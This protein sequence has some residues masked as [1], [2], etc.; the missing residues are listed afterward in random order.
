MSE[1]GLRSNTPSE[2]MDADA[3]CERCDTVNPE[4]TLLCKTC[5]NNLRDQRARRLALEQAMEAVNAG[6]SRA[7]WARGLLLVFGI[8]VLIWI[9]I[10]AGRIEDFMVAAQTTKLGDAT[11]FWSGAKGREFDKLAEELKS[12]P[13]TSEEREVAQKQPAS[14]EIY[15]GRY[16]LV[17][18]GHLRQTPVGEA[19]VRKE[20]G[21]FRI[22]AVFDRSAAQLRGEAKLEGPARIAARDTAGVYQNGEYYG[23]SGFAQPAETGGFECLGLCDLSD[24]TYSAMAYRVP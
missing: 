11:L 5:G 7:A 15:E 10:N 24:E 22:V 20:G 21:A 3:V 17:Q 13:I 9:A 1:G 12:N 2:R 23:A 6:P 8:L 16:V 18:Q 14:T 4:D 19:I